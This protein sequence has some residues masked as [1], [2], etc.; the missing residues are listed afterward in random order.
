MATLL[1]DSMILSFCPLCTR[2]LPPPEGNLHPTLWPA[3]GCYFLTLGC[4]LLQAPV[5]SSDRLWTRAGAAGPLPIPLPLGLQV[6]IVPASLW[7]LPKHHKDR[8]GWLAA[9]SKWKLGS[10][11]RQDC[12]LEKLPSLPDKPLGHLDQTVDHPMAVCLCIIAT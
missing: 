6:L 9:M 11:S 1:C 2:P 8:T 5:F 10:F 3:T 12:S 7:V 4:S